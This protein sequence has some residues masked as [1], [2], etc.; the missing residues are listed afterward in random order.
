MILLKRSGRGL[1][2]WIIT[3]HCRTSVVSWIAFLAVWLL[4]SLFSEWRWEATVTWEFANFL[5]DSPVVW[6]GSS[7]IRACNWFLANWTGR[8][9]CGEFRV[10]L[11]EREKICPILSVLKSFLYTFRK[12]VTLILSKKL[13]IVYLAFH[14]KDVSNLKFFFYNFNRMNRVTK[15][16]KYSN[17][18]FF[19]TILWT[20]ERKIKRLYVTT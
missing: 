10:H 9:E 17:R 20:L 15:K 18:I 8:V 4:S 19:Q 16:K 1:P 2:C 5:T 3:L 13:H 6:H 14:I 12:F 7:S 11:L